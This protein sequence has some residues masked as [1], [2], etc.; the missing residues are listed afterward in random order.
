MLLFQQAVRF[1]M[2]NKAFTYLK[3]VIDD[4]RACGKFT[5]RNDPGRLKG[6]RSK[7]NRAKYLK[8]KRATED[9]NI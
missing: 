9:S 3:N 5:F 1:V 7:Y 2:K 8:R 4:I 6:Y